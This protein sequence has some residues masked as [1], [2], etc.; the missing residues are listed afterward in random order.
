[1]KTQNPRNPNIKR[2][3]RL[4]SIRVSFPS[5]FLFSFGVPHANILEAFL[6]RKPG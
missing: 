5:F 4:A 6:V 1:M 3:I 2:T